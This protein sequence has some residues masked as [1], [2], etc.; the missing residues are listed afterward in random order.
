MAKTKAAAKP[1]PGVT[2]ASCLPKPWTPVHCA[3]CR[4]FIP[5]PLEN[6]AKGDC[7]R[8]PKGLYKTATDWCGEGVRR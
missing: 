5:D 1:K 7:K 6:G 4:Y 2:P 3:R 8:F